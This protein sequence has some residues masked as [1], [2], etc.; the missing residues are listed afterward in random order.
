MTEGGDGT[1]PTIVEVDGDSSA[2]ILYSDTVAERILRHYREGMSLLRISKLAEMPIYNVILKWVQ[3]NSDFR[4]KFQAAREARALTLE[5]KAIQAAE[6]HAD[7][8]GEK[9]QVAAGRL[10]FDAYRWGAE[11]SDPTKYGK[12]VTHQGDAGAPIVFQVQT[13]FP[14]LPES[15]KQPLLN[16]DGTVKR[17]VEVVAEEVRDATEGEESDGSKGT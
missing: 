3:D 15:Q 5:E 14:D 13:G 16:P 1:L 10:K 17:V 9:E 7:A 11:V 6:D 4:M 2:N 8:A 12:K